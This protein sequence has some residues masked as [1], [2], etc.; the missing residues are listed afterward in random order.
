MARIPTADECRP[1]PTAD[2]CR[3]T[4]TADECRPTPTADECRPTP[5]AGA[6][7][8]SGRGEGHSGCADAGDQWRLVVM[9]VVMAPE[10]IPPVAALIGAAPRVLVL[11]GVVELLLVQEVVGVILP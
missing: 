3:P 9:M 10:I 1:T 5:T 2:E 7:R 4:P 8:P 11:V 6:C